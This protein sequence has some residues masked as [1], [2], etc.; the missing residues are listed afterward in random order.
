MSTMN[1]VTARGVELA[2]VAGGLQ[3]LQ[4]LL[5]EIVEQMALLWRLKSMPLSLLMTW[6]NR[7]RSSCS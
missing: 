3:V 5:V 1:C 2:R 4:Q 6:R 7:C